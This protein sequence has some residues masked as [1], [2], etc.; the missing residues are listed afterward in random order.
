MCG[1]LFIF[2]AALLDLTHTKNPFMSLQFPDSP[3]PPVLLQAND[4]SKISLGIF[5][6]LL[7][8]PALPI[9]KQTFQAS[10]NN[11]QNSQVGVQSHP[12]FDPN[13]FPSYLPRVLF[14]DEVCILCLPLCVS[15][16]CSSSILCA[17]ASMRLSFL[18]YK[19][20]ITPP[21]IFLGPCEDKIH[22]STNIYW[23]DTWD[24]LN[25]YVP[26]SGTLQ[27]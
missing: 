1:L 5:H 16:A 14:L 19:M 27:R 10:Q 24:F 12:N 3:T 21:L 23:R 20:L 4:L 13:L 17:W 15:R 22:F 8:V 6:C 9:P 18:I 7:L 11:T 2:T 26:G 25:V